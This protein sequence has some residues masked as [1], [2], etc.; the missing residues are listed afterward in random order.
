MK[1]LIVNHYAGSPR[2]GMEYRPYYFA[3]EW[4]RAGHYVTIISSS[5]SH[6]RFNQPACDR[7]ITYEYIEGIKYFWLK[8]PE[9]HGN[10]LRRIVNMIS[11]A[12]QVLIK[13]IPFEKPDIVIDSSTYPLTIFG[14]HKIARKFSSKLI[15]EVHDLWPLS[16]MELGGFSK[17]HPFILVMQYAENYA[18]KHADRVVSI[19]PKAKEYMVAHGMSPDKFVYIPNGINT[20]AWQLSDSLPKEHKNLLT[21]LKRRGKFIVGYAGA[22]GIANALQYFVE[23]ARLLKKNDKINFLLVGQGPMKKDL[24]SF[25]ER[26]KLNNVSFLP[27]VPKINIPDIFRYVDIFYIAANRNPLYRFGV[28][29]NKMFDYMLAGK[30]IINAIDAGNDLVTESGCGISVPPEDPQAIADAIFQFT[31]MSQEERT[32]MGQRGHEYVKSHHDYLV[33]AKKFLEGL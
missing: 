30:P 8:T 26:E 6:L 4:I 28:S 7:P 5:F 25:A 17:W 21:K 16:P 32:A 10:N 20:S 24:Q 27:V 15:F 23:T 1:I 13:T 29:P 31:L 2:Y 19:V 9:Y 18:Y 11:F 33:L 12:M 22:H 14:L 3:K